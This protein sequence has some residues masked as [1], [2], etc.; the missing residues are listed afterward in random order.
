MSA[1]GIEDC[2]RSVTGRGLCRKHYLQQW[3]AG[4]ITDAPLRDRSVASCPPEHEHDL[5][6][7]WR[8]HGC[9]C[10]Q[11]RHLRKM[12]RQRNR[13]R[14]RAYGRDYTVPRVPLAPVRSHVVQLMQHGGLERIADA[15][16]V[17][18][19]AVLDI[20]FGYRGA[21]KKA[22]PAPTTVRAST[23]QRIMSIAPDDID[24]AFVSATGTR[25]RLQ[26]LVAVG[27]SESELARALGVLV[28]NL[29]PLM[30]GS[31][32]RVTVSTYRAVCDLFA[33]NW[34]NPV[35]SA[36]GDRA[37]ALAKRNGWSGPLAWDDIDDPTETPNVV[38][39]PDAQRSPIDE[40][41]VDL[42]VSGE[43]VKLNGAERRV[44]VARLHAER[45]S[46]ARIAETLHISERT[47]L[48]IRQ[49]LGLKAFEYSEL[50]QV[51]AA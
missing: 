28:T 39:D 23:A 20:Y 12:E 18:R 46:D 21:A 1:C 14:M 40:M 33:A 41:A 10:G 27:Y 6:S 2:D 26:A 22:R 47:A 35:R 50:R 45:W 43:L 19:S 5:E 37:R 7:C 34:A 25:R 9:R 13:S 16:Q 11:C 3:R 49:E 51:G 42:A 17:S 38:G 4:T 30:L 8:D 24:A 31:R 29:S 15:A 36:A 44:A 48:R 32:P